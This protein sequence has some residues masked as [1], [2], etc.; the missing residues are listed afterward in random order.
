LLTNKKYN[1]A[2]ILLL[3]LQNKD[4]RELFRNILD[5][6]DD[7]SAIRAFLE[8]DPSLYKS[9]YIMKFLNSPKAKNI[10]K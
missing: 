8:F 3:Y 10:L 4:V 1:L 5:I 9:K 2:N 7:I 6:D